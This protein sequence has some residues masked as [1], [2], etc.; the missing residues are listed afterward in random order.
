LQAVQQPIPERLILI[1]VCF[2]FKT[3]DNLSAMLRHSRV[4][5]LL[6][7]LTSYA[8]SSGTHSADFLEIPVGAEPASLGG[9]Y[10]ARASNAYAPVWN[11][12]AL[13][14]V[15]SWEF[16]GQHL[17]YLD[18]IRYEFASLAIPLG[19]LGTAAVS[20]QY[21]TS[22]DVT[23]RDVLGD[24]KGSFSNHQAAYTLA[25]GRPIT[26]RWFMGAAGKLIEEK[27][28]DVSART[29]AA[30]L[31]L[32]YQPSRVFR[33]ALVA[34]NIGG[35]LEFIEG[36]EP[37]PFQVRLGG[38]YQPF[39]FLDFSLD[40]VYRKEG[41]ESVHTGIEYRPLSL[42]ALRAG[43]ATDTTKELSALAGFS[44]GIGVRF[45][46]T[47]LAYAWRPLGDLGDSHYFSLLI[48]FGAVSDQLNLNAR[49]SHE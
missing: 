12:G 7:V 3:F 40:G 20:M 41:P 34:Q 31:G 46:T 38:V 43:Y 35:D 30:D 13:G 25:F 23:R 18:S 27:L 21:L 45:L 4:A 15:K 1:L 37:L 10:S 47:E 29:G 33:G 28:D 32:F 48:K 42:I 39:H 11:P 9:A 44:S 36:S 17:D 2:T 26:E 5:F 49:N 22:G 19:R 16:A 8:H 6:L 14:A 24:D